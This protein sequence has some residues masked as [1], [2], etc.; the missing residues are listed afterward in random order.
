MANYT[1]NDG[2]AGIKGVYD[3]SLIILDKAQNGFVLVENYF[4]TMALAGQKTIL[5]T[6][7]DGAIESVYAGKSNVSGDIM[8]YAQTGFSAIKSEVAQWLTDNGY[9][10]VYDMID[11]GNV[12]ALTDFISTFT[13]AQ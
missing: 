7:G 10:C 1:D 2:K 12:D 5:P 9:N 8:S 3:G 13:T 11:D 6:Y 4:Q